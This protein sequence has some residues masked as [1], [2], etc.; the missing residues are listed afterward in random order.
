MLASICNFI[1]LASL[2]SFIRLFFKSPVEPSITVKLSRG[3][4]QN[5]FGGHYLEIKV[6]YACL[7]STEMNSIRGTRT[8]RLQ[9]TKTGLDFSVKG[10]KEHGIPVVISWILETS[11]AGRYTNF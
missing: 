5:C 3:T 2:I 1:L 9:R 11:L 4:V 10:G 8:V 7:V 6:Y